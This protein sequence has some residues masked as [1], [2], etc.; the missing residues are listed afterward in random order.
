MW[1]EVVMAYFMVLSQNAPRQNEGNHKK[2][3]KHENVQ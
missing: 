2:S 3:I 1:N